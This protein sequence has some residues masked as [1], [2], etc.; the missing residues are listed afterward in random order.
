M[1]SIW[2]PADLASFAT[3]R[4]HDLF[5][6]F[7]ACGAT[8]GGGVTRLCAT[9]ADG[10]AR[11]VM[12]RFLRTAGASLRL[13]AV[14]NQYGLFPLAERPD[15]PLVMMGS[16]LDSQPNAGRFDGT[17][18]V[19]AAL[20]IGDALLRAKAAGAV[21]DAD[22]CAVNWT[23]EE[24][25]RFRPSLLGSGAFTGHHDTAFALSR[26]DDGGT[27]LGEAL[28]RIG[29]RGTDAPPPIPASY[30]ELHVEQ[31]TVLEEANARI[32]IVTRNWGATKL[33]IAFL[34]EQAHTGPTVMHRRRDALLAAA[35]LIPEIREIADLWPGHLHTSVGRLIVR[36][37]SANVVPSHVE[38]SV[39]LRSHDD[40]IL[41]EAAAL[42]AAAITKAAKRANVDTELLA[43]SLRPIRHLPEEMGHLVARSA[44]QADLPILRM[45]TVAGHDALSL[46]GLCPIGLVF[47][48]SIAGAAHNEAEATLDTDLEAG[49]G[50]CLRVIGHLCRSGGVPG[51]ESEPHP[52]GRA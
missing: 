9:E 31:G 25:A 44:E 28:D 13:D 21:F 14:G 7:S 16:H 1:T 30:L 10:L 11:N 2:S 26:V 42:A 43:S 39:E 46:L 40:G 23:N 41:H 19:A 15:A 47:V 18:G 3:E 49:I 5:R 37:N 51:Q 33:E 24:G 17:F 20:C 6:Q 34:G 50:V 48:P 22:F 35:Y 38:L 29:Q 45:D 52:A 36:P 27:S 32:G 12:V 8:S 4:F